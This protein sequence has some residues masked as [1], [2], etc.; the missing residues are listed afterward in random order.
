MTVAAD[1][2]GESM[3]VPDSLIGR[4]SGRSQWFSSGRAPKGSRKNNLAF[5][6]GSHAQ[7]NHN[8]QTS[9]S[10][11][12]WEPQPY[13]AR[14]QGRSIGGVAAPRR[15]HHIACVAAPCICPPGARA[16]MP[17][18]SCASPKRKFPRQLEMIFFCV[19][20]ARIICHFQEI[21]LLTSPRPCFFSAPLGV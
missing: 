3:T 4:S 19:H 10:C 8:Q 14:R 6:C 12:A 1:L 13:G 9:N 7:L 20:W 21:K 15:C 11:W 5:C 2:S 16:K 17:T 18:Y